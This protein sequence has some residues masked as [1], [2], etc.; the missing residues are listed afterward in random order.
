MA[1]L[2]RLTHC[3]GLKILNLFSSSTELSMKFELN[4]KTK[5]LKNKDISCFKTLRYC[6]DPVIKC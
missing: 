1:R 6:I 5:M 3:S 4:I 2:G